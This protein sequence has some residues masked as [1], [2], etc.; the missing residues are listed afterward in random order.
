MARTDNF[1]KQHD[2]ILK[3]AGELGKQLVADR[4]QQ[5]AGLTVSLLA[6]LASKLKDH[7]DLQHKQ[8]YPELIEKG[9]EQVRNTAR[10]FDQEMGTF[11]TTFYQAY[12]KKWCHKAVIE[13]A[14]EAFID[15]TQTLFDALTT[16][17]NRENK[18]LYPLLDLP[19]A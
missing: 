13:Q 10:Q 3:I 1:R 15:A 4:L 12:M 6:R 8:L 18:I 2:D 17:I 7:L 11:A 19:V 5:D 14:P 16:R 9:N